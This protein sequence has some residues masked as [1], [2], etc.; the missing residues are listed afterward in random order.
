MF[1]FRFNFANGTILVCLFNLMFN[2]HNI[3]SAVQVVLGVPL[4]CS[5][6]H[7]EIIHLDDCDFDQIITS[8]TDKILLFRAFLSLPGNKEMKEGRIDKMCLR[9]QRKSQSNRRNIC[10]F[11]TK[12]I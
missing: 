11:Y 5:P 12:T 6:M 10:I 4:Q 2:T 9:V 8:G 1:E 3:L 7:L